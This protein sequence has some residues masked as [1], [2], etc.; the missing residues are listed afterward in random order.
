MT[1]LDL[2]EGH[3]QPLAPDRVDG[4][5]ALELGPVQIRWYALAYVAGILIGWLYSL[6]IVNLDRDRQR[7]KGFVTKT[8]LDDFLPW[9]VLGIIL[10]GRLGY[11]LF[12]QLEMYLSD[13]LEIA[14]IWRGGMAFHGGTLGVIFAMILFAWKRKVRLLRLT[15]IVC[16]AVPIGLL[17]GR[18]ANFINGEL[19][20]RPTQVSWGMVFPG[21]G[22]EPRHPS[23][24]Y[25]AGLEGLVLFAIL[26]VLI[27][28]AAVRNR[29]G[30]VSGI[31]LL[32]YAAARSLVE[33][34]R[35]PDLQ[36]G[37]VIGPFTMGQLLSVPMIV[38]GF[39]LIAYAL[40]RP[41]DKIEQTTAA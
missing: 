10:G 37:F 14:R 34:F 24:L 29:P 16:A 26:A 15:D 40:R 19:F 35:Q 4:A 36:L 8:H 18:I 11:V 25:E 39:I 41:A 7:E 20:G 30:I 23:Q 5:L 17:F 9:A 12:Y 28:K 31:F 22:F 2:G 6:H 32:G 33:F 38:G 21:G 1:R 3:S 13:P 27:H